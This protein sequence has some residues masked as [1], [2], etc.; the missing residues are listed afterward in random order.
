M[1]D[2]PGEQTGVAN[3]GQPAQLHGQALQPD[4]Q[5]AMGRQAA[6][7]YADIAFKLSRVQSAGLHLGHL[8]VIIVDALAACRHLQPAEQQVETERF[9]GVVRVVHHIE[10]TFGRGKM[11]HEHEFA[12][13]LFP[14]I[15]A[16]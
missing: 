8:R 15:L 6:A 5:A 7:V 11:R 14:V 3:I 4:A 10:R 16:Q 1:I 12:Q 2:V 9:P 13:P